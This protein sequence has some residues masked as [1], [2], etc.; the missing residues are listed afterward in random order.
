MKHRRALALVVCLTLVAGA[1]GSA[2]SSDTAATAAPA[3]ADAPGDAGRP[4]GNEEP[5]ED[6]APTAGNDAAEPA[7]GD[8]APATDAAPPAESVIPDVDVVDL[9]TGETVNL[10]SFAPA[11][12][13]ILLWFWAPH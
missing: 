1:C 9:A 3:I 7:G 6:S 5:V 11:D 2:S 12:R 13:P 8:V 4:T 10:A